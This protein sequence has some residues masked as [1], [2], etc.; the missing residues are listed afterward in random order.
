MENHERVTRPHSG[1]QPANTRPP[2]ADRDRG[3]GVPVSQGRGPLRLLA[4]ARSRRERGDRGRSG[5]R[6]RALRRAVPGPRGSERVL[7]VRRLP[8]QDRPLRRRLLPDLPGRGGPA[9]S[10]AA[11]DAGDLLAGP[12]GRGVGSGPPEG[13]PHGGVCRDQQSRLPQSDPVAKGDHRAGGQ[14]LCGERNLLQHRHRTG[15][16]RPRSGRTGDGAGHRVLLVSGGHTP[17][18]LRP[19]AGRSGSRPRRGRSPDPV[20]KAVGA[21]RQGGHAGAGR[22]LQDLRRRGQRLRAG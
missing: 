15:R 14:P 4:P 12:G 22:A 16:L 2:T 1:R 17:G 21:A 20:G 9:G 13:Q 6:G 5:L 3:N 18:G 11:A 7:P 19:A 10:S 8:R